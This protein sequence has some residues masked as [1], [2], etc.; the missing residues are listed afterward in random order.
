MEYRHMP[1]NDYFT[2]QKSVTGKFVQYQS[3]LEL[4]AGPD[5]KEN[6]LFRQI[7]NHS[8]IKNIPPNIRSSKPNLTLVTANFILKGKLAAMDT[9]HREHHIPLSSR[10]RLNTLIIAANDLK[11]MGCESVLT[12]V[13]IPG[14]RGDAGLNQPVKMKIDDWIGYL[15][16]YGSPNDFSRMLPLKG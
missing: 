5:S 16:S 3:R 8:D 1:R 11:Q 2:V 13:F 14:R 10:L 6:H 4:L 9:Y 7:I 15:R 12:Y